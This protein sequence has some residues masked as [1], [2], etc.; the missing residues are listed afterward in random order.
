MWT[1]YVLNSG[2]I[3]REDGSHYE[4]E[5]LELKWLKFRSEKFDFPKDADD[6]DFFMRYN[7][8]IIMQSRVWSE[9]EARSTVTS[10]HLLRLLVT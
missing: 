5:Q 1:T 9:R 8:P 4:S 7:Y 2:R 6:Q 3:V 10:L